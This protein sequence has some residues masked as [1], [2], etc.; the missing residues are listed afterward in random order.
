MK[1]YPPTMVET[2]YSIFEYDAEC[3]SCK[4]SVN[5]FILLVCMK[6]ASIE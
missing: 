2:K 6:Y 5:I 4:S 1:E 3:L